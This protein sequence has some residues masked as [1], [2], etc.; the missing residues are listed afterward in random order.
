MIESRSPTDVA[1]DLILLCFPLPEEGGIAVALTTFLGPRAGTRIVDLRPD[2]TM[3]EVPDLAG[4]DLWTTAEFSR[5]LEL[6]GIEAFDDQFGH[7]TFRD[8]VRYA[9]NRRTE[10]PHESRNDE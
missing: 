10:S 9:A 6:A 4:A 3:H 5:M 7:M 1:L 2:T 8:F